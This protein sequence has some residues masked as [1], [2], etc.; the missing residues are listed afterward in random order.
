MKIKMVRHTNISA[1]LGE[2]GEVRLLRG[3]FSPRL[4]N[5]DELPKRTA[6]CCVTIGEEHE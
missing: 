6:V 4:F 1:K 2:A 3:G 5:V